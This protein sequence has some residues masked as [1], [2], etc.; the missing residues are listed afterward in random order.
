[1]YMYKVVT[2]I[3]THSLSS[4][5]HHM[6]FGLN[7]QVPYTTVFSNCY[8]PFSHNIINYLPPLLNHISFSAS[9][10][11]TVSTHFILPI[12]HISKASILSLFFL[13]IVHVRTH[14]TYTPYFINIFISIVHNAAKYRFF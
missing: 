9:S 14:I 12:F 8:C 3:Y 2:S 7:W 10:L 11:F 6:V 5:H 4:L 1:M 13:P